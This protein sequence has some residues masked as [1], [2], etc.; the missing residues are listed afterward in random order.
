MICAS[1]CKPWAKHFLAA[2]TL[3]FIYL[4]ISNT[5][6]FQKA[7]RCAPSSYSDAAYLSFPLDP[8][9]NLLSVGA[10]G[11]KRGGLSS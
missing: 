4:V 6:R 11:S 3:L 10:D 9:P 2:L 5:I 7:S 1:L 8:S